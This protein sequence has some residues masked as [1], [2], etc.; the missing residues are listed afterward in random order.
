LSL[1]GAADFHSLEYRHG[2]VY[3]PDSG[4]RTVMVSADKQ[5]WDRRSAIKA[6]DIAVS[7]QDANEILATT[8][9]DDVGRDDAASRPTL[10]LVA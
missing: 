7:P 6:V 8:A 3:G 5:T 1:K 4:T 10:R 2:I 9:D